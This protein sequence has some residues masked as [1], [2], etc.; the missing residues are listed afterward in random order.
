MWT[1]ISHSTS[2]MLHPYYLQKGD[3]RSTCCFIKIDKIK[4]QSNYVNV[5]LATLRFNPDAAV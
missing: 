1:L 4:N 3:C 2:T 5:E